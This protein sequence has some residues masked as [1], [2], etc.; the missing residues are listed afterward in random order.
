MAGGIRI[1]GAGRCRGAA[2]S[3]MVRGTLVWLVAF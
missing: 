1:V 3:Q 2:N